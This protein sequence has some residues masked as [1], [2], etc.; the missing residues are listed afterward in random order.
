MHC[1]KVTLHDVSVVSESVKCIRQHYKK[2]KT[3]CF[4]VFETFCYIILEKKKQYVPV[5]S[6]FWHENPII[7]KSLPC[8]SIAV[9]YSIFYL[10]VLFLFCCSLYL[11][12][13]THCHCF[14]PNNLPRI[15]QQ[16]TT[17]DGS[18]PPF[19]PLDSLGVRLCS[20]AREGDTALESENR[21]SIFPPVSSEA[22]NKG[23]SNHRK[24]KLMPL[25]DTSKAI[26]RSMNGAAKRLFP[27]NS[28]SLWHC[29]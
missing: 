8:L 4:G 19:S 26:D 1:N 13:I 27:I 24:K 25:P 29:L 10:F 16:N 9:W 6:L 7:K 28:F 23:Y 11:L 14:S 2:G 22:K 18:D 5:R 3:L 21:Q 15:H 17:T 20:V 12:C